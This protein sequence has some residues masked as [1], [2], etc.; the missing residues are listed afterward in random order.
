MQ[1]IFVEVLQFER[2]FSVPLILG[3]AGFLG[4][5][6]GDTQEVLPYKAV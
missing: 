2:P 3:L 5:H 1:T 6:H 4:V